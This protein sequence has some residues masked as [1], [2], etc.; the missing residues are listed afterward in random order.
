M[1]KKIKKIK[2]RFDK[3]CNSV[4]ELCKTSVGGILYKVIQVLVVKGARFVLESAF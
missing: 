3:V 2:K 4:Q 1:D